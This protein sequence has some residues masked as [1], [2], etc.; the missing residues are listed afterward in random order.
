MFFDIKLMAHMLIWMTCL[1]YFGALLPQAFLNQKLKSVSG[2]SDWMLLGALVGY[3]GES[4]YALCL[5]LPSGYKVMLPLGLVVIIFMFF[6]KFYYCGISSNKMVFYGF[7][8]II[9]LA[10][11]C[12]P[13]TFKNIFFVGN[14]AGWIGAAMW[15]TYKLPQ[16]FR[17]YKLKSVKGFSFL[18]VIT[19]M[20][21]ALLELLAV[22]TL[23]LP[24]QTAFN[25]VY[26][27]CINSILLLQ[28]IFYRRVA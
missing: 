19:L 3:L 27:V 24:T 6:Q 22:F 8:S 18:F 4:Y 13:I 28:F 16:V 15:S 7:I 1:I 14:I 10:L 17:L 11:V 9:S 21:G 5:D 2:I 23:N 20:G 26:S 25:A 12:L